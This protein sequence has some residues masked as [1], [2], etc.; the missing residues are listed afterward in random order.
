MKRKSW[1]F[2]MEEKRYLTVYDDETP[3]GPKIL[4]PKT[5]TKPPNN[6]KPK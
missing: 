3:L 4:S 1:E 2:P 6:N 5:P